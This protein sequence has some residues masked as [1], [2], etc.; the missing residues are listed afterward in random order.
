MKSLLVITLI[1]GGFVHL[2]VAL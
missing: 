2:C 1:I